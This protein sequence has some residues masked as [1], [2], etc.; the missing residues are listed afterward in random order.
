MSLS[1]NKRR[2]FIRKLK[3]AKKDALKLSANSMGKRYRVIQ[4]RGNPELFDKGRI[5]SFKRSGIFKK[6][7]NEFELDKISLFIT[8]KLKDNVYYKG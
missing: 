7:L 2:R 8:P 5:E 3:R 4:F 6:G 1:F